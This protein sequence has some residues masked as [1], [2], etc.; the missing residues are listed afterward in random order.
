MCQVQG[1]TVSS[2]FLSQCFNGAMYQQV[3]KDFARVLYR[4]IIFVQQYLNQYFNNSIRK[5]I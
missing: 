5:F 3:R 1:K 4:K 2:R